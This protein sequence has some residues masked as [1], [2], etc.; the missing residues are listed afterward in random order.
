[1][2]KENFLASIFFS[3]FSFGLGRAAGRLMGVMEGNCM[4][5]GYG[6]LVLG[7]GDDFPVER[8]R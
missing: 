2:M 3:S 8:S 7:D 6:G 5:G 1:M 4:A